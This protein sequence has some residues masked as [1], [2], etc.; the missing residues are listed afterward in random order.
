MREQLLELGRRHQRALDDG[1]LLVVQRVV[2]QDL[3]HEAVDLRLGQ[4]VGALRLDR[5]LGGHDQ[6]RVGHRMGR[7]PERDLTL[8][9]DLEQGRLHLRGRA[10]DLVREQ[11]VA[12]HGAEL[13]VEAGVVGPVDARPDEVG[14]HEVRRELDAVERAAED[15]RGGLHRERLG[16]PR[17]ALDQEM[18]AGQ[19]AHEHALEH[20]V[21]ARD[22]PPDLEQ[23]LLES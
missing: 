18:T 21:L 9:H 16:Q 5:V 7:V 10:V 12:E 3:E 1:Q 17:N 20:L 23:R 15:V 4:R 13:G 19:E 22:D 2:D 8:L 14:R 11:E 6:E